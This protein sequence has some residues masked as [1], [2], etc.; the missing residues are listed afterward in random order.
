MDSWE[1]GDVRGL[2]GGGQPVRSGSA[3]VG[4]WACAAGAAP[5]TPHLPQPFP[6]SVHLNTLHDT[7]L[8]A[9]RFKELKDYILARRDALAPKS[10]AAAA[11]K[12]R[13]AGG[14]VTAEELMGEAPK[15]KAKGF[16]S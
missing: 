15:P 6:R 11:G 10:A 12:G 9:H 2:K 5:S 7:L 4:Q 1:G 8:H 13:P 16:S 14:M 3:R